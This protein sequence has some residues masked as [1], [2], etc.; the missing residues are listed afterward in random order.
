MTLW[1]TNCARSDFILALSA[2]HTSLPPS[3][4]CSVFPADVGS[5]K[6]SY[7]FYAGVCVSTGTAVVGGSV[8]LRPDRLQLTHGWRSAPAQCVFSAAAAWIADL[9]GF[10]PVRVLLC[11]RMCVLCLMVTHGLTEGEA[12]VTSPVACSAAAALSAENA[13]SKRSGNCTDSAGI[14]QRIKVIT[15]VFVSL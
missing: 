10:C 4:H 2:L 14:Q 1:W 9:E 5:R 13:Q 7:C 6:P 11:A 3:L 12:I 8:S 15:S